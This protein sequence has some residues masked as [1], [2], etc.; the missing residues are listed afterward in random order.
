MITAEH[1]N[2]KANFCY[3]R[4]VLNLL[5]IISQIYNKRPHLLKKMDT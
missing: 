1:K 5:W 2:L 4:D 3:I